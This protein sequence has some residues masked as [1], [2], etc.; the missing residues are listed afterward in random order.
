M[1]FAAIQAALGWIKGLPRGF[2]YAMLGAVVLLG[3]WLWHRDAISDAVEA[4]RREAVAQASQAA[5]GAERAANRTLQASEAATADRVERARQAG[6]E[7]DDP[8]AA[9]LDSLRG[10]K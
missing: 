2:H 6:D 8:L 7:S 9:I 10:K 4:D 1:I 3:A 5:I